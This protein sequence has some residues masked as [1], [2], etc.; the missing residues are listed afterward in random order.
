MSESEHAPSLAST[1][2]LLVVTF[3]FGFVTGVVIF[4]MSNTGKEGDGALE[5]ETEVMVITANMY[6]GCERFSAGSCP[7]YRIRADGT[8]TFIRT[9]I[10]GELEQFRDELSS[11]ERTNLRNVVRD[12]NFETILRS[13]YTGSCPV[14]V[15]GVAFQ[16]EIEYEGKSYALD[17][18]KQ[19]LEGVKLFDTLETY[20]TTFDQT[21]E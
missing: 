17:S 15:D 5:E 1:F 20:F 8:Y 4:L 9:S 18:C 12:T 6:G 19:S 2:F 16:Y 14:F 7:S 11:T 3:L 13:T 21:Y 10:N